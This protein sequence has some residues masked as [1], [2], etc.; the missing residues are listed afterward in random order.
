MSG[1]NAI[2]GATDFQK[3]VNATKTIYRVASKIINNSPVLVTAEV[4]AGR[5]AICA[6]CSYLKNN[7]CQI[8][9]CSC[10]GQYLNKLKLTSE[11]CP[12]DKWK[13]ISDSPANSL[14]K[15]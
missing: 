15:P 3:V 6:K 4:L 10:S 8:C 9:G 14:K 13:A 5:Q 1:S 2:N 12:L 11:K 7:W